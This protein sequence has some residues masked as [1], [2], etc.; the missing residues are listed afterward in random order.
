MLDEIIEKLVVL[1]NH[2]DKKPEQQQQAAQTPENGVRRSTRISRLPEQYSPSL[3]YVL[4]TD[5][6][7]PEC[8]E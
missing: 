3:Y 1:E 5:S 7:E 8:Y 6:G 2:N 4:L